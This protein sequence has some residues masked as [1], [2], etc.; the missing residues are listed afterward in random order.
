MQRVVGERREKALSDL[1]QLVAYQMKIPG[2][3]AAARGA[4]GRMIKEKREALDALLS[5]D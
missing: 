5:N 2:W 3:N 1:R 4:V